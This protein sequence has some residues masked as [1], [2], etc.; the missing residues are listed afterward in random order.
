M[1]I[2]GHRGARGLAPENTIQSLKKA[3][4][5]HVDE[6]E[7][8]VR[9]TKDE[10][11]VL[12][13]DKEITGQ[14]LQIKDCTYD[15]LREHDPDVATLVEALAAVPE[16]TPLQIEIKS[17]EPT[18]PVVKI[19]H[20]EFKKGRKLESIL[21]GSKDQ[22]I[23]L[24]LHDAFP[25]VIKVVIE[26]W[27]GVRATRHAKQVNTKRISMNQRWLWSGFVRQMTH[28]GWLLY[29][30]TVNQPRRAEQLKKQGLTGIF[31]DYPDQFEK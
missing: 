27:S 21:I 23:L 17:G 19:L 15:E 22:S 29:A 30:Y 11:V 14:N 8:D 26:A 28:R 13:H 24:I 6:I 12:H 25:E 4:E 10:I 1:K 5:H 9:V 16:S 2:V 18:E 31:T 20:A 7:C 3:L